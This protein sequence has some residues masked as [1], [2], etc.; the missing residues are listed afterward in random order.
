MKV[1]SKFE[2]VTPPK[3]CRQNEMCDNNHKEISG[4]AVSMA[5]VLIYEIKFIRSDACS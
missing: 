3:N 5:L 1:N 4:P 2:L